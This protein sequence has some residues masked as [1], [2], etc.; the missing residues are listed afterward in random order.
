MIGIVV[1]FCF[2]LIY[3]FVFRR[4]QQCP[5]FKP[6]SQLATPPSPP[7]PKQDKPNISSIKQ[8]LSELRELQKIPEADEELEKS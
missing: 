8:K 5:E 3:Y 6:A 1:G 7:A 4:K 2:F